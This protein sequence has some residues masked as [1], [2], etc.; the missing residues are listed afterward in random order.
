MP[1]Q[2]S[3]HKKKRAWLL[4]KM[5]RKKLERKRMKR[6]MQSER[7][8]ASE[9]KVQVGGQ[10]A[11]ANMELELAHVKP[12]IGDATAVVTGTALS[13]AIIASSHKSPSRRSAEEYVG[14]SSGTINVTEE[15]KFRDEV[16]KMDTT[17]GGSDNSWAAD[18]QLSFSTSYGMF[19]CFF[20]VR[21]ISY[22]LS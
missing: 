14:E 9:E 8:R 11:D 22:T 13:G 17:G 18:S 12:T 1:K 6:R 4:K 2:G 10:L 19:S 15:R 16:S 21:F 3:K 7:A 5:E 20:R